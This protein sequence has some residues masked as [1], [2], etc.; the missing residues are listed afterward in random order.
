LGGRIDFI[1]SGLAVN[2]YEWLRSGAQTKASNACCWPAGKSHVIDGLDEYG[3][4]GDGH[5][6]RYAEAVMLDKEW[7][8]KTRKFE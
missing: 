3:E 4:N 1:S 6:E 5:G 2:Q 7:N 8:P